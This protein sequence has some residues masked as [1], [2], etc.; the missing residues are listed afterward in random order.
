MSKKATFFRI[1]M[2]ALSSQYWEKPLKVILQNFQNIENY[3][4]EKIDKI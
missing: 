1:G 3:R 2:T 4:K